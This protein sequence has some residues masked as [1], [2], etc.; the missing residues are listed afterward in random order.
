LRLPPAFAKTIIARLSA[1]HSLTYLRV[2]A[3]G[4]ANCKNAPRAC[5]R[6]S[7]DVDGNQVRSVL[8][9][10]KRLDNRGKCHILRGATAARL[11]CV[12][13]WTFGSC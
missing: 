13:P 8:G 4:S 10:R 6:E 1:V 2:S 3:F 5:D 9:L 11:I 7:A 12:V